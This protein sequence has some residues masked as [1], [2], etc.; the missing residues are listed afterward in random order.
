MTASPRI[1]RRQF[2]AHAAA[3]TAAGFALPC[4]IP[5]HARGA[6]DRIGIGYIGAGRRANQLMTLPKEAQIVAISD[7]W[8]PR[9]EQVAA[10]RQAKAYQ[11]YRKMLESTDVQAVVVATPDHWHALP[12]IHGCQAGKDVY[13]EKPLSLTIREG[14]AMVQAARKYNRVF[15]TGSQQRSLLPCR[16]GCELVRT[17]RIGKVHTIVGKNYPSPWL[18]G[19]PA[20]PVPDG[21]DWDAWCGPTEPRAYHLD[22]FTPRAKPGWISFQ[23][24]SGGEM[25]GWG[26]HGLDQ[27]QWGLGT[28]ESGPVEVWA[29]GGKLAAPTYS[30]PEKVT[31]GNEACGTGHR[32]SFRYANGAILNLDDGPGDGCA[33]IG[34]QGKVTVGRKRFQAEPGELAKDMLAAAAMPESGD[35]RLTSTHLANWIDCIKTRRR[36]NAD[37]EIGHRSATVC[38]LGNIA[39]WLGRRL[40]WDPVKEIF[41]GDDEANRYLDRPK[42]K[43]YQLPDP[44]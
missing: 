35:A 22:L 8:L 28:D 13:C 36:P 37:V 1:L 10:K 29:D 20:Q 40:R 17:G 41:P 4:L 11:D 30:V 14:R 32:V 5:A 6:N 31:R 25:T 21:L 12:S 38:H 27:V 39:R 42:R 43:P 15:Q 2:L 16:I 19:L 24:Y 34:D 26:A 7:L 3:A 9:A 23:P 18:C 33:F 44:V